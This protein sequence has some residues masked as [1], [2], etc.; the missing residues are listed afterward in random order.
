MT[1]LHCIDKRLYG[2]RGIVIIWFGL[3]LPVLLGFAALAVDVARL[4]MAKAELQNAADNAA[5]A[6]ALLVPA[7]VGGG[8]QF[9][10]ATIRASQVASR[11]R[12]NGVWITDVN[13][14]TGYWNLSYPSAAWHTIH[15]TGDVPAY[16]VTI[17]V[18][19]TENHGPLQLPF[20][21]VLGFVS[22]TVQA[23]AIAAQPATGRS[24]LVQ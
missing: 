21:Q 22:S 16:R 20:A 15:V 17:A 7:P 9:A 18:S 6:G 14:E 10:L 23:T 13:I 3:L 11:H 4:N 1:R 5:R 12:V 8:Y 24:I 19:A 2:Q